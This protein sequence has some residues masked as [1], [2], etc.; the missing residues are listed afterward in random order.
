M[1]YELSLV[2]KADLGEQEVEKLKTLVQEVIA[3]DGGE[4]L[5]NDDWGRMKL[6]QPTKTGIEHGHF[7]YI[8]YRAESANP[9]LLR[10]FKIN[11]N[12]LRSMIIVLGADTKAGDFA[13]AYKT[14]FSKNYKGSVTDSEDGEGD[15][16]DSRRFARSR[17]CFFGANNIKAD[18]KDPATYNWL[19]NEFGKISPARVSNISTKHQRFITTAIKRARQIGVA[20]YISNRVA[21]N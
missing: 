3:E 4:I 8:M 14:P 9:E 1:I 16:S 18:W 5:I 17:V 6:A 12:V 13:K 7:I 10:R 20:S 11:E 21:H 2:T 15:P 19:V